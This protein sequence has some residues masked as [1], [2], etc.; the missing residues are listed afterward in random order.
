LSNLSADRRRFARRPK[1]MRF[2]LTW[3]SRE[4]KV[5]TTDMSRCGLFLRSQLAPPPGQEVT[6]IVPGKLAYDDS[7]QLTARVV[8]IVRRG[9]P[10]N[11]LGGI[12]IELIRI[13]SPLGT[14]PVND[15]LVSLLGPAAPKLAA[16]HDAVDISMPDCGVSGAAVAVD[17]PVPEEQG[18]TGQAEPTRTMVVSRAVF[19][20]WRNMIIQA[21]LDRLGSEQAILKGLKVVPEIGDKVTVRLMAHADPRYRGL[22][23]E[24]YV[25]QVSPGTASLALAPDDEQP[26][27]GSLRSFLRHAES[28]S[29]IVE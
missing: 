13:H 14:E 23:F 10:Y 2:V 18:F 3:R 28:T 8:R 1:L 6:L 25:D 21:N 11:P 12:G 17:Q 9:D 4:E 16:R 15:L 7:V 5:F 27:M 29:G 24:G 26:E 20:R 19:C 22:Q